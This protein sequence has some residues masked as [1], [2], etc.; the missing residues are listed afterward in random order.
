MLYNNSNQIG[1]I[2]MRFSSYGK[3]T[4]AFISHG[5]PLH[6]IIETKYP[7][8]FR[9][10]KKPCSLSVELGNVCNLKCVYCNIPCRSY[11]R[12]F[13]S[14]IVFEKLIDNLRKENINR[15]RIGGGEPTLHPHF[16][17]YMKE[18]RKY[19]KFLSIVTNVQ[20]TRSNTVEVL[21]NTPFDMIEVSMDVG[22]KD[23]Y[24]RSRVGANYELFE[25]NLVNLKKLR[26]ES[27]KNILINMRLMLRP[28]KVKLLDQEI[29]NW[30]R[31]CDTIMPQ[32]ITKIPETT[33]E[34]D[35][36]IPTQK[37]T[38]AVPRCTLPFKDILVNPGGEIPYCQVTGSTINRKKIIAGTILNNSILEIWNTE[39]K[40]MRAA[41]RLRSF[42]SYETQYCKGC[43]GR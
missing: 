7:Y 16:N 24:E 29:Q 38:G 30:K 31:Y 6:E 35:I 41:H 36:F 19:T 5:I 42:D 20:W 23:V 13:M 14:E 28:S 10:S 1:R 9:D 22:G 2:F 8:Y 34:E 4:R 11:K 37:V 39:V 27:G 21:I 18:I 12:E 26:D 40:K 43:S 33:Y 3:I 32:F 17:D 25:M 15:I